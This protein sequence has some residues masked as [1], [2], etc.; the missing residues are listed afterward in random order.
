MTCSAELNAMYSTIDDALAVQGGR[1]VVR[2]VFRMIYLYVRPRCNSAR[3]LIVDGGHESTECRLCVT[4]VICLENGA[5]AQAEAIQLSGMT[6]I[7]RETACT[8]R[9]FPSVVKAVQ[10][11]A[12]AFELQ[13][14]VPLRKGRTNDIIDVLTTS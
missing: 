14:G 3:Q 2:E 11:Y 10:N 6:D 5:I 4:Q 9:S 8:G 7:S 1:N 12:G 13:Y